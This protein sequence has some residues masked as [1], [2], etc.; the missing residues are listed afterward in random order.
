MRISLRLVKNPHIKKRVVITTKA[1]RY[2]FSEELFSM[3]P[4]SGIPGIGFLLLTIYL[5]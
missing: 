1:G 3:I 4:E 5:L 2:L